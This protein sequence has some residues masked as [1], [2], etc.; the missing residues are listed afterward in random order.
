MAT[1]ETAHRNFQLGLLIAVCC[2]VFFITD[3]AI[4]SCFD[5]AFPVLVAMGILTAQLTV[6]C[7]WGTLVRGT[8][9][10]RLPWTLLLLVISWCGIAWGI[11]IEKGQANT[12]AML[13]AGIVW[14]FGF[15]TSFVPLKIAAMGFRWQIVQGSDNDSNAI[16]NSRYA[17]R[18]VMTGT[19]LLALSMAIGRAMLP[20]DDISF[21]RAL[22]ASEL[23]DPELLV[24]I[25][26]YGIVSLLVKLPCIW[27]ALGEPA[28]RI[29]LG[30]GIWFAYCVILA[31]LEFALLNAI[32]GGVGS[33][34]GELLI[35]MLVS[36]QIMGAIMLAVCLS[37]RGMGYR[38]ERSLPQ[39]SV[40]SPG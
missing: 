30:I 18:D 36:H 16:P 7:V 2:V 27:I 25:T 9:W 6:I 10:I 1:T 5:D 12:D 11:T 14:T 28:K 39:N 34:F 33:E 31:T 13:G 26:I 21:A 40:V 38:L 37:L 8:F 4:P 3:V 23:D 24:V 32:V 15:V 35:G 22:S 19:L 20:T 29:K 17:I